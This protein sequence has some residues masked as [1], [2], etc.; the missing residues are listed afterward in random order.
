MVRMVLVADL[1]IFVETAAGRFALSARRYRGDVIDP[2]GATRLTAFTH[3]P[4]PRWEWTLPDGSRFARE[5]VVAP[6][7]VHERSCFFRASPAPVRRGCGCGRCSRRADYHSLH[8]ENAAYRFGCDVHGQ[9]VT[10]RPYDGVPAIRRA[11]ERAHYDGAHDWYRNAHLAAEAE[12]GLDADEDLAAPGAFTF[13][14]A[15]E[16]GALV[17]AMGERIGDDGDDAIS[18]LA[19]AT[20]VM[21]AE[22]ARRAAFAND[23]A[24]S[25][26]AYV[27]A[28]GDGRTVIAGY[29]WF[30]DWG[31]DTFISLRGLCL[32]SNAGDRGRAIAAR[33]LRQWASEVSDGMLPNRASPSAA[34]CPSTTPSTPRCGS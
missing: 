11:R 12:R 21:T 22:R 9:R 5:L 13:D 3:A 10:W 7:F 30:G 8:H 26:S 4:W 27:V 28:R 2:D 34:A 17:L 20:R 33:I 19:L 1:K 23:L 32:T 14:L 24:R 25:A 6:E 29:P 15:I 16:P 31:R 18:A